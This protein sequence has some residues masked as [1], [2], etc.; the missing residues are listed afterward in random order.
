MSDINF[1]PRSQAIKTQLQATYNQA[2]DYFDSAPLT[3]WDHC[4]RRTVELSEVRPG[5]RVLD[6]CCGSGASALAAAERAGQ[7]GHVLGIDLAER[8]LALARAKAEARNL[9]NLEFRVG[10]VTRLEAERAAYDAVVCVFGLFFAPDMVAT[11]AELWEA[12]R[13]GGMLCV[14]TYGSCLFEPANTLYWEAIGAERPELRPARFAQDA[15]AEPPRLRRLYR[16][17]GAADP[18]IDLETLAQP[19]TP[20]DFWTV[21]LGTGHRMPI[22]LMG[23]AAGERV[24]SALLGRLREARVTSVRTDVLYARATKPIE[25]AP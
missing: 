15:I 24:R 4:G 25:G 8:L 19:M 14:T 17:A 6:L 11:L 21:V 20:E 23:A 18:E 7:A 12:V 16:D 5:D 1:S 3:L 9:T 10:D 22:D 13:P 2:A